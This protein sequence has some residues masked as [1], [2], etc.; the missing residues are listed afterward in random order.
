M[1]R[2]I[3]KNNDD[4]YQV[5][6]EHFISNKR[7]DLEEFV[8]MAN[9]V[10]AQEGHKMPQMQ[11]VN[12]TLVYQLTWEE[13]YK[14][15]AT[16]RERKSANGFVTKTFVP[17]LYFPRL[18]REFVLWRYDF[19]QLTDNTFSHELLWRLGIMCCP[20]NDAEPDLVFPP[21]PSFSPECTAKKQGDDEVVDLTLGQGRPV[22][23][24]AAKNSRSPLVPINNAQQQSN[25]DL[26]WDLLALVRLDDLTVPGVEQPLPPIPRT[27][28]TNSRAP[29]VPINNVQQQENTVIDLSVDHEK[30]P[31][32]Q[33]AAA[34]RHTV[35]QN[36][37]GGV[38]YDG[39]DEQSSDEDTI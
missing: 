26:D 39:D 23:D 34:T 3:K 19:E 25:N 20:F 8:E 6:I 30:A 33:A 24:V 27:P 37:E 38:G 5:C 13:D 14:C 29:L 17:A 1:M 18:A 28:P 10:N 16:R 36:Y 4:D 15:P 35:H 12:N 7:L 9:Q 31:R 22:V 2:E 32:G 21:A 11:V